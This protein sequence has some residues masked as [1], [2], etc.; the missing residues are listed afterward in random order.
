MNYLLDT[1]V[2]SDFFKKDPSTIAHFEKISPSQLFVSTITVMEI[3]YGLK[4]HKER[5][6]KIRPLWKSL[7]KYIQVVPF[8]VECAEAA[9]TLRASLKSSGQLIGP[10]D[11]LIAATGHAHNMVLVTSNMSEFS[12]VQSLKIENWRV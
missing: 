9:A 4:L 1:C 7:L 2:L 10:F 3:E 11:I 6:I 12:R 5:E 8:S